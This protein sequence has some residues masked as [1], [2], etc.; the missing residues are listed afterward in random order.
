METFFHD[1]RYGLRSLRQS[2]G[3]AAVAVL[4]LGLGIGANSAIFSV[5]DAALLRP[6]PFHDPGRLMLVLESNP[7]KGYPSFPLS[8]L[9]YIDYR[10]QNSAFERLAAFESTS[11]ILTGAGDPAK[12]DGAR[13]AAGFVDTLGIAP[14]L[15]RPFL[16]DEDRPGAGRVAILGHGLWQRRFGSDPAL[17]GRT[18]MLGGVAYTVVGVMPQGFSFPNRSEIWTA[19]ALG[20]DELKSRGAH[21]LLA[22]G[23]LAP[24]V[25]LERARADLATIGSRLQIQY[26]DSNTGWT[27]RVDPLAERVAGDARPALLVLLAAVAFVLLIACANVAG[28]LLARASARH[29]EFAIRAALGAGRARLVRQQLTESLLLALLGG[30]AGLLLAMWGTDLLA[31][32]A[33]PGIPRVSE[34]GVDGRVLSFTLGLS[35]IT[36]VLFGLAPALQASRAD[37]NESLKEGGRGGA[38]P[39]RH[40]ARAVLVVAEVALALVLLAGAGLLLRSFQRLQAIDP[41]FDPREVL[42][43]EIELPDGRYPEPP[44]LASFFTA[45]IERLAA[46]PGVRSAGGVYPLPMSGDRFFF[47]FGVEGRPVADADRPSAAYYVASPGYFRAMGIRILRG[48]AFDERDREGAP[49]VALIND[50]LARRFFPGEDPIGRRMVIDNGP[51]DRFREIVG[52]VEDVRHDDL[53]GEARPQ[54][55]EPHL[56]APL[57]S[58]TLV[59]RSATDPAGLAEAARRE[60]LVLDRDQPVSR[61]VPLE[62]LVADSIARPR[63][64]MLLLGAFA[65]VALVL[66]TMGIYGLL[67]HA[68]AQRTHEI[69]IRMALGARR[70]DVLALV[71][72]NGMGLAMAGVGIGLLGALALTRLMAGL[73]FQVSPTDPMTL[74]AVSALLAGVAFLACVIPARRA[75]RVDPMAALRCE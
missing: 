29:R 74:A 31:A 34:V 52:V 27:A 44:R 24:G 21:Y 25:S 60:I 69:G 40:R 65:A 63:Y 35:L 13:V 14:S 37:L 6:L 70:R 20:D 23:R 22:I 53:G 1:L 66:A 7:S 26:P 62:R 46:L 58:M 45:A 11:F 56:Q 59:V 28:L 30:A 68:V 71:I 9:N 67:S 5:V 43:V 32:A 8:P 72:A 36:G 41:G 12:L 75:T 4:A 19:M 18:I 51:R 17:V 49:R 42:A 47:S 15:G 48:R 3:L 73:L 16:P 55:Y 2:P 57:S 61:A 39:R 38:G 64:S 54:M 50:T 10:D 33:P